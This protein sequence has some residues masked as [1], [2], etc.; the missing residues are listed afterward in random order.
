MLESGL[1]DTYAGRMN[2]LSFQKYA[3]SNCDA[4][5]RPAAQTL[6]PQFLNHTLAT[7]LVTECTSLVLPTLPLLFRPGKFTLCLLCR[8]RRCEDGL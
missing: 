1:L 3:T 4:T 6:F 8:H 5:D 2:A 7:S